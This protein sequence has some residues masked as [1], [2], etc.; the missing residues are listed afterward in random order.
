MGAAGTTLGPG[1]KDSSPRPKARR[2]ST[3]FSLAF[4]APVLLAALSRAAF[5]VVI[6]QSLLY[7]LPFPKKCHPERSHAMREAHDEAESK[8][9]P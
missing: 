1:S 5:D 3:N 2:F 8:S 4:S 7:F 9:L 6:N